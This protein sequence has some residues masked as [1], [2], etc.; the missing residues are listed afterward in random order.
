MF[1]LTFFPLLWNTNMD[2][3]LSIWIIITKIQMAF[4]E[5]AYSRPLFL[6]I[7]TVVIVGIVVSSFY[8]FSAIHYSSKTSSSAWSSF[9]PLSS[10]PF[11]FSL[12]CILFKWVSSKSFLF[13]YF[14]SFLINV[15]ITLFGILRVLFLVLGVDVNSNLDWVCFS[16]EDSRLNVSQS[17]VVRVVPS[18]F[19]EPQNVS[20]MPVLNVPPRSKKMPPLE[21][22]KLTKEL[23]QQRVKDNIIIVTFGNYAFMDFILTWVKQL[24]DLGLSNYLVGEHFCLYLLSLYFCISGYDRFGLTYLRLSTGNRHLWAYLEEFMKIPYDML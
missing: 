24:N 12:S 7:Y 22:F 9:P 17:E 14:V 1:W 19:P 15:K 11:L 10:N 21:D 20:K 6:T 16:D 2:M 4:E 23:V 5:V 18:A 3:V 8:V 13:C